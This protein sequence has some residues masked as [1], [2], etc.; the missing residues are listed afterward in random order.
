V[1]SAGMFIGCKIQQS[2]VGWYQVST[3]KWRHILLSHRVIKTIHLSNMFQP[4]KGNLQG[5]YMIHSSS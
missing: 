2:C 4:L 1:I 3:D 5:V